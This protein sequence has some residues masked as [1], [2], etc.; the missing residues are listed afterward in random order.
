MG[1]CAKTG[2]AAWEAGVTAFELPR[3][4]QR[5]KHG[6]IAHRSRSFQTVHLSP[7]EIDSYTSA[8]SGEAPSP[9]LT[10]D[11]SDIANGTMQVSPTTS[12][13]TSIGCSS[14]EGEESV[15]ERNLNRGKSPSLFTPR[16]HISFS[17][18]STITQGQTAAA[19]VNGL[20]QVVHSQED[21]MTKILGDVLHPFNINAYFTTPSSF[22]T[23]IKAL[24]QYYC[25]SV[26]GTL[27]EIFS[28][29]RISFA[30]A[31]LLH[32]GETSFPWD[33]FFQ[34]VVQWSENIADPTES[35]LFLEAFK[36]F[37]S[38]YN[39]SEGNCSRMNCVCSFWIT[40]SEVSSQD[41]K[42]ERIISLGLLMM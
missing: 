27:R 36:A 34:E 5:D 13:S 18:D 39:R 22:I 10:T 23:G 31:C 4:D 16:S 32:H 6:T 14:N 40:S 30:A 37:Y 35:T 38:S 8:M 7:I 42:A 19:L 12:I 9:S 26:L 41:G 21:G 29:L 11:W 2:H 3:H 25:G 20:A 33:H 15:R 24:Q 1:M 17:P 28:L